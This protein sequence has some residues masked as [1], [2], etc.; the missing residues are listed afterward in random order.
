MQ[1]FVYNVAINLPAFLLA[2]VFHEW[3]HARVALWFGDD[4]AER[5]GRLTF[6]PTVHADPIG[7]LLFPL[8]G[9]AMGGIMFGW[10]R[11][12]PVDTRRFRNWKWGVFWVSFAGPLANIILSIVSALAFAMVYHYLPESNP[13]YKIAIDMTR[14]SI[15]MNLVL[16]VFNLIPF[17]PLDGSKMVTSFLNYEQARRYEELQR[18]SFVFLIILWMTPIFRYLMLPAFA[19]GELMMNLFI[20]MLA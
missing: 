1:E 20:H 11:P 7:T 16:A 9:A 6:N 18:Y 2:I 12:V 17:P 13:Y 14:N 10:A 4:T 3:S 15:L 8:V 5:Q 19:F